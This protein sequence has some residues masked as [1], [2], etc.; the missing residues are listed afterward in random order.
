MEHKQQKIEKKRI[1]VHFWDQMVLIG[2]GLALFYTVFD[3]VLYI[4]LSYDVDFFSRLFG[5]DISEIWTR[6]TIV[7]LFIIFGSHAQY[8][9]NKRVLAESALRESEKK[10][11]SIVETTPDGYYEVDLEGNFTF[12]NDSMCMILGYSRQ[13]ISQMNQRQSLDETNLQKLTDTFNKVLESGNPVK[14]L[15]WTLV[16]KDGSR[17]FVESSVSLLKTPKG[18]S[19]G[20]GG[21]IR[22]VTQRHRAETLYRAKMAA[23]AASRI[24][25]E[26]LANMSH[27]IRTPLNAIIGL[28]DLMLSSK[29]PPNQREDLDVVKSSAYSLLSI[30]NNI[31]DFSKIEAGKLEFEQSPFSLAH[32]IDDSLKIMGMKSHDKGIELAYRIAP[33]VPDRLLGDPTRLRQ[34]LLNLVDNAIKFTDNGEVVIFVATHTLT[35]YDVVLSIAVVDTGIG[36]PKDKQR[37]IFGAYNQGSS[38]TVRHYGGTGLGLAV[39][40]QLVH[41]MDGRI[42]VRSQPGEGSRFRFTAR[43]TRQQNGEFHLQGSSQSDRSFSQTSGLKVLVTDD[44]ASNRKILNEILENLQMLPVLASSA[45]EAKEILLQAQSDATPF[46]LI[47]LDSDMPDTDGFRLTRWIVEQKFHAAGIIM[48]LTF[49]HLKRKPELEALGINTSVVKPVGA[50]E[51]EAAILSNHGIDSIETDSM[52]K[53]PQRQIR[54]PNQSLKILVAEDTPFNQK[55]ILRLLERWNHQT[56]L[57]ENGRRALEI[58]QNETFDIVLM[59]VQ[60]P[61]MDG[62]TATKEFRKWESASAEANAGEAGIQNAQSGLKAESSEPNEHDS[63]EFSTS[64]IQHPASSIQHRVPIIAMTAHAIKGDRERCLEAGMNE[65]V[66]KPIDSDKLFE[67]IETLTRKVGNSQKAVADSAVVDKLQLLNAFDGDWSF[68]KE[69]VEV[70]LSDYPRLMVDLRRA[71]TEGDC[72]SL[73]RSAHSLKGMLRNFQAEAAAE[74]AFEIEKKAKAE[75]FEN[76]QINI[77]QLTDRITEVDK[78]LRDIVEQQPEK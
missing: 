23:E 76:V 18:Q 6:I 19:T 58:L 54:V 15:S 27:E 42:N 65:Y 31:L 70:F 78:M 4:F 20:F 60:M 2:I 30:I 28:V 62:L 72:D 34:V 50:A 14:S 36:I 1:K 51:L 55:F 25:S 3:S 74:V 26:F 8:T 40:A 35:E 38:A 77:E 71:H 29:L 56:I 17:R 69:I 46:D 39:S 61:E 47:I 32:F 59:D 12:F 45:R 53:P 49:P 57:V 21:F 66:S 67:A 68:L 16:N 11:R 5:P 64:S 44:N 33:G 43:F 10:F 9:I 22:D 73:M 24:K 7:C 63:K 41:L 37:S 13:E 52:V 75:N 48:M